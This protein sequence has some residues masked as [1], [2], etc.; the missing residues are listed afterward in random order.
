MMKYITKKVR[1]VKRR[2]KKKLRKN[3]QSIGNIRDNIGGFS[4]FRDLGKQKKLYKVKQ[5]RRM[6]KFGKVCT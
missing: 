2:W 1:R 6:I 3:N 5:I 4:K